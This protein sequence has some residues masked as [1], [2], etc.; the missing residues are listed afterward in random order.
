MVGIATNI[1]PSSHGEYLIRDV[2]KENLRS[3]QLHV[4]ILDRGIALLDTGTFESLGD[5]SEFVQ[6]IEKRQWMK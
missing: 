1:L 5:V 2:N 6:V 3:G 4:N